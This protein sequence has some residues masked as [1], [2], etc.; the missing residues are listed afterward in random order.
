MSSHRSRQRAKQRATAAAATAP[1]GPGISIAPSPS[2]QPS[3]ISRPRDILAYSGVDAANYSTARGQMPYAPLDTAKVLTGGDRLTILKKCRWLEIN[4]GYARFLVHGLSRLIGYYT[5]QPA[6][7]DKTWNKLAEAHWRNRTKNA[8]VFDRL[9]KYNHQ[10]WQLALTRASLRDGDVLNVMTYAQSG[11]A[12][13]LMYGAHQ[14]ANGKRKKENL[15]DGVYLDPLGA[16]IGYNLVKPD[17]LDR[18]EG[19]AV[20]ASDC[21]YYGDFDDSHQIRPRPRFTH[22]VN[23]LHDITEIDLESKLGIKRRQF[24]GI[25]RK[26]QR[27]ANGPLGLYAEPSTHHQTITS[28]ASDG[29]TTTKNVLVNVESAGNNGGVAGLEEGEDFGILN[30]DNPGPNER[31]FNKALLA[32]MLVGIGLPPSAGFVVLGAGGPEVRFHMAIL[33]RWIQI[34]LLNLLTA[35]QAHYFWAMG[36]DMA[37]GVLPFPDD[38]EWWTHIAIPTADLTIDRGRDRMGLIQMLKVGGATLAD[39][40]AAEGADWEDKLELQGEIIARAAEIASQKGLQL[41]D[42]MPDW[43]PTSAA[44]DNS[45]PTTEDP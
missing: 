3:G 45:P 40:Y 14:V 9:G 32:K 37:R 27:A 42:L 8:R 16:H 15:I 20:K 10:Q 38:E 2:S 12:Q 5:L 34:E 19:V 44:A 21:I 43:N 24:V 36:T 33:Q 13:V 6:T 29:S 23:D 17:D 26:R 30:A 4:N 22:A 35:V 28:T 11:A 39:V 7:K 31:E 25:Y 41:S 1:G 18:S